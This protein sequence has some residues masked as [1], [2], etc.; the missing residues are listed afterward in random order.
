MSITKT[1]AANTNGEP[2]VGTK[3]ARD[4]DIATIA[5]DVRGDIKRAIADGALPAGKYSVRIRRYSMA[6]SLDITAAIPG[7][8]RATNR[9]EAESIVLM[10][11]HIAAM[12]CDGREW[13][14][15]Y[16]DASVAS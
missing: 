8:T 13:P 16:V 3:Y 2:T 10:L 1:G 4:A 7:V 15:F 14:S 6:Q 12:Y 11:K 9:V 5:V